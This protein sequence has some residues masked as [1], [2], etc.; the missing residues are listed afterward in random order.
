MRVND[1]KLQDLFDTDVQYRIPL[2]QRPYVWNE[3]EQWRYLWEDISRIA[4]AMISGKP[5]TDHFMGATVREIVPVLPGKQPVYLVIDGQQRLTTLHLITKACQDIAQQ[6]GIS[7]YEKAFSDMAFNDH[8]LNESQDDKY[9]V[10]PTNADRK[11]F[12][13]L[14]RAQTPEQVLSSLGLRKSAVSTRRNISDAYIYFYR[15]IYDWIRE[16]TEP[17]TL[18]SVLH[19]VIS[20][21]LAMVVIELGKEDDAQMIFET[22]NARGEPLLAADLIKNSILSE[23]EHAGEPLEE[24]YQNY[25]KGFDEDTQFWRKKVGRGHA[26]KPRLE[27]MIQHAIS[28]ISEQVVTPSDLYLSYKKYIESDGAM[29]AMD[30]L[31]RFQKIGSIFRLLIDNVGDCRFT[32]FLYRLDAMNTGTAF[33]FLIS[34]LEHHPGENG[35]HNEVVRHIE[36]FLVRRMICR[37]NTR[38]YNYLFLDLVPLTHRSADELVT[39]VEK[40]LLENEGDNERWP[41]DEEF[42]EAWRK[43]PFYS[44][45]TRARVRMIL[46]ALEE[47]KIPVEAASQSCPTNLTIEHLLPQHWEEYW[48]IPDGIGHAEARIRRDKLV[49]SIGNLTLL[50]NKLNAR[51]KNYPWQD[52]INYAGKETPGKRS[53]L[54]RKTVLFLNEELKDLDDWDED[55]IERRRDELFCVAKRVWTFPKRNRD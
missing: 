43:L 45:L 30:R 16:D 52:F 1:L 40:R 32:T 37:L 48:P 14:M 3:D 47:E 28:L 42:Y 26:Q 51:Q 34:L 53:E 9:T 6:Y 36:S 4:E 33:P 12:R 24:I 11:T 35:L 27:L 41:N 7:R 46:E 15:K 20:G 2:Y 54:K 38:G 21:K 29:A 39:A 55:A 18:L 17:E 49:H 23:L 13:L 44:R 22:M 31:E 5:A 19:G 8:A 25:W 10:L 50:T